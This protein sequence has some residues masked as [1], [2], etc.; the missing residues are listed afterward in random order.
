MAV[1]LR[2]NLQDFGIAE[3]F[4]LIGQQR[5]TGML[6]ISNNDAEVCLAFDH[7]AVVWAAPAAKSDEETL[8]KRLICCG[9]VTAK[10]LASLH[11]EASSSGRPFRGLLVSSGV[12]SEQDL[13]AVDSLLTHDTIFEVL[14]WENGS[15]HFL[16]QGVV[17]ERP[18]E[19]LLG[20]EQILMNGL[21]MVDEWQVFRG[22][23]P[24]LDTVVGHAP[25]VDETR[26]R[27]RRQGGQHAEHF[28]KI[29]HLI[30]GRLTLQRVID[31]AR[32]GRFDASRVVAEM[33]DSGFIVALDT[34]AAKSAKRD[35]VKRG[36][37]VGQRVV[38]FIAACAPLVMLGGM[39]Y[40][41]FVLGGAR[42]ERVEAF[43]IQRDT[44]ADA[45][46]MFEKRRIR[47]AIEAHRYLVGQWPAELE[48]LEVKGLLPINAMA[49]RVGAAYYY[50]PSEDNV[51]LLAPE[52]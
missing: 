10:S 34:K 22:S 27:V 6:K 46:A 30:D 51:I 31:L 23:V 8:G 39:V 43:R 15:F 33:M 17:H 50:A 19:K 4:Q 42:P 1:A 12:A 3:V 11:A 41:V 44:M 47:H 24:S 14:R 45:K 35:P 32:L 26:Q 7:G 29:D 5:K 38:G 36:P 13:D 37:S 21:R 25:E 28:E 18:Q 49:S 40:A 52:R 20:A 16:S 48:D 9:Y 2:G